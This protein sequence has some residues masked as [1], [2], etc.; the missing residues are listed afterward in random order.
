MACESESHSG[1]EAACPFVKTNRRSIAGEVFM[2]SSREGVFLPGIL[3]GQGHEAECRV[4]ATKVT[5]PGPSGLPVAVAFSGY[6]IHSVSKK[7]PDGSYNLSV[8]A[9]IIPMRRSNGMWFGTG[10]N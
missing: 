10:L 9:E 1:V 2:S 6:S 8:N 5:L 7:L 3:Q 4:S